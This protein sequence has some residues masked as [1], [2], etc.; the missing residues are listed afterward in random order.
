M[1]R[2][3]RHMVDGAERSAAQTQGG[4]AKAA[5]RSAQRQSWEPPVQLDGSPVD[6][7]SISAT[8]PI[9]VQHRLAKAGREK[10]AS[11]PLLEDVEN[12]LHL[13]HITSSR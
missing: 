9:R 7:Y 13:V 10:D 11:V 5:D 12:E 2:L 8:K 4:R 6:R 1:Q 3:N